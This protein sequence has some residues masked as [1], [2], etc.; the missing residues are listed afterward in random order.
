MRRRALLS[1]ACG[2]L[3]LLNTTGCMTWHT[4][5]A[6]RDSSSA[7]PTYSRA[8]VFL[9]DGM[10]V[11]LEDVTVRR[12]SVIGVGSDGNRIAL[13]QASVS[14]VEKWGVGVGHT[15]RV[16]GGI[17]LVMLVVVVALLG[18]MSEKF[19]GASAPT[20]VAP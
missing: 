1:A 12:D 6:P 19:D 11:E 7:D 3:V 5:S 20:P 14:R 16:V 2:V 17:Y 4:V 18:V 15:L 10:Q 9:R 8:R 13:D